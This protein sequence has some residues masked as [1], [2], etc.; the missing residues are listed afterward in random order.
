MFEHMRMHLPRLCSRHRII[1]QSKLFKGKK[2]AAEAPGRSSDHC[3]GQA[4]A[5]MSKG[6]A[7]Y[8]VKRNLP[9]TAHAN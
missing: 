4:E 8:A 7:A 5:S 6:M 2:V 9:V 3:I 1:S